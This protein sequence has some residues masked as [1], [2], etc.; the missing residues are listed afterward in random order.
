M[1]RRD[2]EHTLLERVMRITVPHV[3][4][5]MYV[6]VCTCHVYLY[7]YILYYIMYCMCTCMM[8]DTNE[9]NVEKKEKMSDTCRKVD[10]HVYH[11]H[12][13]STRL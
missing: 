2:S 10:I 12:H 8:Y 1:E 11:I 3:V 4:W 13:V 5:Y 6:H 9:Q 7:I